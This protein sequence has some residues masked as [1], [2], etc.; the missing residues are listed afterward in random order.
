MRSYFVNRHRPFL[1][2]FRSVLF[3]LVFWLPIWGFR[4]IRKLAST[5]ASAN[6]RSSRPVE[7]VLLYETHIDALVRS[8]NSTI[9]KNRVRDAAERYSALRSAYNGGE[10]DPRPS[11]PFELFD[12]SGHRNGRTGT[13][14]LFRKNLAKLRDHSRRSAGE[15]ILLLSENR[16]ITPLNSS[17]SG[18]IDF[19]NAFDDPDSI[20]RVKQ[21][22]A[23]GAPEG[24]TRNERIPSDTIGAAV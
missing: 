6:V 3:E 19:F 1:F 24:P 20:A 11:G 12:I 13:T 8:L 9:K 10:T 23:A 5:P 2:V 18:L 17:T 7:G 21:L 4:S 22:V 14:C 16:P 15:L